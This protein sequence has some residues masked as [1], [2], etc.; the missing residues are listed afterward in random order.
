M[1]LDLAWQL[2]GW[3]GYWA[4]GWSLS[5]GLDGTG[6]GGMLKEDRD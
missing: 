5:R 2:A 3:I 1:K 4:A 6:E